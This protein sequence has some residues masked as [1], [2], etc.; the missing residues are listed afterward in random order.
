MNEMG[1]DVAITS[2]STPGI[3]LQDRNASKALARKSTDFS[4]S[5]IAQYPKRFGALASVPIPNI[6]D[7]IAEIIYALDVLKPDGVVLFTN[8]RLE[9]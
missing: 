3:Q 9:G 5:L 7:A 8:F 6:D 1:I 4:A 2:M